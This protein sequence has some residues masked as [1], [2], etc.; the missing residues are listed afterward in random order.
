MQLL[1]EW[2]K[3]AGFIRL[4]TDGEY[5]YSKYLWPLAHVF[6]KPNEVSSTRPV[7]LYEMLTCTG[8]H[9]LSS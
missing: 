6:L 8:F 7:S 9:T 3:P 2:A 5:R 4:F 1:W